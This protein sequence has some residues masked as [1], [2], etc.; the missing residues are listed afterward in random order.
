MR[1]PRATTALVG[2]FVGTAIGLRWLGQTATTLILA[3][4][5]LAAACSYS[6]SSNSGSNM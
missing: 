2:A 4:I 6:L 1:S 5:L 3:G